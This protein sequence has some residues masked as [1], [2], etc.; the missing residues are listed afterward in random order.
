MLI[1]HMW[2]GVWMVGG[3]GGWVCEFGPFCIAVYW[4]V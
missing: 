1:F 4:G 3:V 2:V